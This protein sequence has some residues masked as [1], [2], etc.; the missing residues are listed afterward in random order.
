MLI[1]RNDYSLLIVYRYN[2]DFS[3]LWGSVLKREKVFDYSVWLIVVAVHLVAV[4]LW[5]SKTPPLPVSRGTPAFKV[6]DLG[7]IQASSPAA[8]TPHTQA[9]IEPK[10]NQKE[11]LAVKNKDKKPDLVIKKTPPKVEKTQ[12]EPIK[13]TPQKEV[14]TKETP[15]TPVADNTTENGAGNG[16]DKGLSDNKSSEKGQGSGN[17]GGGSNGVAATKASHIG[18][19]LHNPQPPYPA[20]SIENGEEGSVRLRVT[21]EADGKP[22][23]VNLVKSSGYPALDR[24]ALKTVKEQYRF[25]PATQNNVAVRSDYTFEIKFYLSQ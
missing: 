12:P 5:Q 2:S 21:V 25:I 7:D 17:G 4:L 9:K 19:H 15:L 10:N 24:S 22:S 6:V 1:F 11:L 23:A 18:G 3:F 13:P 8:A 16:S 20:R 14:A